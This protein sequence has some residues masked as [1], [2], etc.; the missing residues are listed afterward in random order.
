MFDIIKQ[1]ETNHELKAHFKDIIREHPQPVNYTYKNGVLID[2]NTKEEFMYF[3]LITVKKIWR[4]Y[5]PT[6]PATTGDLRMTAYGIRSEK[7][8]PLI[9]KTKRMFSC[10]KGIWKSVKKQ[11]S[12]EIVK[13]LMNTLR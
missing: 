12:K 5:I 13:K 2:L 10:A 3:H 7:D 1:A 6:Y 9:W 8:L 4:F 11:S